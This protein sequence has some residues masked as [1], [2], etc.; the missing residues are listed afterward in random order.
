MMVHYVVANMGKGY[1]ALVEGGANG[2]FAGD[3]MMIL[4]TEPIAKIDVAGIGNEVFDA[5]SIMQSAGLADTADE[6]R[7][8]LIMSQY[9]HHGSGKM[10]HSK[11]QMEAFGC[12][13]FGSSWKHGGHKA[14]L[15]SHADTLVLG[16]NAL[17]FL[18]QEWQ[19]NVIG[20]D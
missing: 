9:G 5:M 6:G 7:I 14:V 15:D 1:S 18:N 3:D 4:K 19:V 10:I 8:I 12:C 16:K 20:Y 11:N 17:V 13:I 2:S